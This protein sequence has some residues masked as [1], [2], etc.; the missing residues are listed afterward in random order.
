MI[1]SQQQISAVCACV[2]DPDYTHRRRH[3]N[4]DPRRLRDSSDSE[5]QT[6]NLLI[7]RC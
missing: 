1:Q 7:S 2:R 3:T 4:I 6:T 5:Y